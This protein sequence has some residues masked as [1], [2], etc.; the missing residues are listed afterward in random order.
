MIDTTLCTYHPLLIKVVHRLES[1]GVGVVVQAPDGH[2]FFS[3]RNG[4][5]EIHGAVDLKKEGDEAGVRIVIRKVSK[6]SKNCKYADM[7]MFQ[8]YTLTVPK[9]GEG[10]KS[11]DELQNDALYL[12]ASSMARE[13]MNDPEQKHF[14]EKK[15]REHRNNPKGYSKLY[16]NLPGFL[17]AT[18][19]MQ[20][21]AQLE[22][23]QAA[24]QM[25][26]PANVQPSS[27]VQLNAPQECP[28]CATYNRASHAPA[29]SITPASD[30][31]I[32]LCVPFSARRSAPHPR[33]RSIP[34]HPRPHH[35]A[36]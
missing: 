29:P 20:L 34:L 10:E 4:I 35:L 5:E 3:P 25:P 32:T 30:A 6:R 2:L 7:P 22:A 18:F 16:P 13:V 27:A 24:R 33:A 23:Q 8:I 19:R 9:R 17:V 14:W 12:Q 21:A 1:L 31:G 15:H 26:E 28:V 11:D 36:A